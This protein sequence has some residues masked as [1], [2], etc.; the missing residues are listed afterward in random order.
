MYRHGDKANSLNQLY[1]PNGEHKMSGL[2]LVPNKIVGYRI[3]PDWFN[4]TVVIVKEY[5]Q[6]SKKHGQEYEESLAYCKSLESAVNWLIQHVTRVEG[7]RLQDEIQAAEGSVASAE[8]L[9][10]AMQVAQA[11]ALEA[12]ADLNAKL[13]AAGLSSPKQ[14]THLLGGTTPEEDTEAE[15]A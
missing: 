7:E 14:L 10:K 6:S 12:V 13:M 9:L 5:G 11:A 1:I 15:A 2:G 4:F 3:K 8:G